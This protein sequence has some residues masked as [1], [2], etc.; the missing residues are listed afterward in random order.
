[1]SSFYVSDVVG[2]T[3]SKFKNNIGYAALTGLA[4]TILSVP[5][6][7]DEQTGGK[8]YNGY[9]FSMAGIE[10]GPGLMFIGLWWRWQSL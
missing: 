10:R 4:S 1:M 7:R 6:R 9:D 3:F 8:I 2:F 5:F